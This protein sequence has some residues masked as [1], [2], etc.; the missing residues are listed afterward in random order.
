[1]IRTFTA[2]AAL[3]LAAFAVPAAAQDIVLDEPQAASTADTETMERMA[4][5]LRDPAT[6][7]ALASTMAV[8][9]EVLLDLPLA[10]ILEP[11]AEAAGEATGE[12]IGRVDPD[13]TLR[14]MAPGSENL[15]DEIREKLPIAM[16]S[17]ASMTGAM[18]KMVPALR[19]MA[20]RMKDALPADLATGR[21]LRD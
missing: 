19:E 16:G 9:A 21:P 18:A 13:A 12:D 20:E 15:S 7:E 4:D 17:M 10:P 8:M 14:K 5:R 1:M 3:P 2:I 6:Q 11:L